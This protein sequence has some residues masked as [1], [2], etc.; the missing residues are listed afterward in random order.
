MLKEV[1]HL[2]QIHDCTCGQLV[3]AQISFVVLRITLSF[4]SVVCEII[5]FAALGKLVYGC[6]TI[7][8]C[9]ATYMP[10]DTSHSWSVFLNGLA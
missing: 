3:H 2:V 10:N 5:P 6:L 4:E 9:V 1:I 8:L 7:K